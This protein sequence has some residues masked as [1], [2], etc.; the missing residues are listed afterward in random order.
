MEKLQ[1]MVANSEQIEECNRRDNVKASE[2]V[3]SHL[4]INVI[5][6]E[7]NSTK[8]HNKIK[9]KFHE[10]VFKSRE[11]YYSELMKISHIHTI[12][13][14]FIVLF[15]F[16]LAYNIFI[17]Y[18]INGRITLASDTFRTGFINVHYALMMW[19]FLK[20]YTCGIYFALECWSIVR[21]KLQQREVLRLLWSTTWLLAYI[22]SQGLFI[23]V[24]AKVCLLYDIRN[25]SCFALLFE[26]MRL[27]MKQHAFVRVI[28]GRE[29]AVMPPF[30]KYLYY[31]F[32]PTLLYRDDYPRT[33]SI[34]W[35]YVATWF[36]ECVAYV[37]LFAFLFENHL[38]PIMSDF[39][40]VE[41]TTGLW[42]RTF[43]H[44]HLTSMLML[45]SFF[46]FLLH[47][48]HNLTAEL[49]FFADRMFHRDWWLSHDYFEFFRNWNTLVGDWLYEYIFRDFHTHVFKDSIRCCAITVYLISTVAH[50][51]FVSI[52]L[53]LYFPF[54]TFLYL[55]GGIALVH[56]S[57]W[58]PRKFGNIFFWL[59]FFI[60]NTLNFGLYTAE[61][62]TKKNCPKVSYNTLSDLWIPHL[63]TCSKS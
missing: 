18:F 24:P 7:N 13:N 27:S 50:E 1:T 3:Q 57:R 42:I 41:L 55:F 17:D 23:Y 62:Y 32:A 14:I 16:Y 39:G 63:W 61:Y 51:Y 34:R 28:C 5:L 54:L 43:F 26:T 52:P 8:S 49:L 38:Q 53:R 40:K 45:L 15:I 6:E 12:Y 35:N 29:N 33:M 21:G 60:G 19:L 48:W 37:C 46:Y 44:I 2:V 47:S 10:K 9:K 25:A 11:S 59:T 31:L 36:M 4:E 58:V 30:R 22:T 56:I 20:L